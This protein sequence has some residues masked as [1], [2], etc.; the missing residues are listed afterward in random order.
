MPCRINNRRPTWWKNQS[1]PCTRKSEILQT[2]R[3]C[4]A[5]RP[6]LK[7]MVNIRQC[8]G[9]RS[10]LGQSAMIV[11]APGATGKRS[12]PTP[13]SLSVRRRTSRPFGCRSFLF[14]NGRG[15]MKKAMSGTSRI[16]FLKFRI[17]RSYEA[18][19][20]AQIARCGCAASASAS[21]RIR[22]GSS[23]Q[24]DTGRMTAGLLGWRRRMSS[25]S[26]W[27][28][29]HKS[30]KFPPPWSTIRVSSRIRSSSR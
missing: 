4:R 7:R 9:S 3:A 8:Q 18:E 26:S 28:S 25:R 23:Y 17:S 10:M 24:Q 21:R 1:L 20:R 22:A 6:H 2:A 15:S 5:R 19:S 14:R 16:R 27:T 11:L 13:C 12:R 29:R 30:P